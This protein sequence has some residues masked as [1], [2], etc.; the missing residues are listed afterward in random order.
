MKLFE[1]KQKILVV[2]EVIVPKKL[3]KKQKTRNQITVLLSE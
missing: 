2:L 1:K 3:W